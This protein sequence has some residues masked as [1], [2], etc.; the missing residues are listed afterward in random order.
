VVAVDKWDNVAERRVSFS[1]GD[2]GL[3]S[4]TCN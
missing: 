2:P 3:A 4:P 1:F